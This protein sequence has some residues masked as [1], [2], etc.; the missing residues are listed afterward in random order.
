MNDIRTFPK[1]IIYHMPQWEAEFTG[2]SHITELTVVLL[3]DIF[4]IIRFRDSVSNV[5]CF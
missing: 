3:F 1:D 4:S 2:S 5:S